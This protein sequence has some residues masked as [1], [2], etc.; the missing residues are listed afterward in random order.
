METRLNEEPLRR[1]LPMAGEIAELVSSDDRPFAI[2]GHSAGGKLAIHVAACL[3]DVDRWPVRAFLSG[4]PTE[5]PWSN[6]LH[7]LGPNQFIRAVGEQFGAL[8]AA[9]TDD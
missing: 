1:F 5:V 4:A 9:I 7:Q 8:P 3:L 6:F 2:F